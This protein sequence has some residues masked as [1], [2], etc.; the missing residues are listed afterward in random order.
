MT[1]LVF[2]Y[3]FG[4]KTMTSE[5]LPHIYECLAA[6]CINIFPISNKQIE[7]YCQA[8][9]IQSTDSD[10]LLFYQCLDSSK[11]L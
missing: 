4:N 5:L 11:S 6:L 7:C 3:S 10:L 2:F 1:A 8:D 9:P